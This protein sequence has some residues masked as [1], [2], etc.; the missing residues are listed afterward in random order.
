MVVRV[1]A[2]D[3]TSFLAWGNAPGIWS[4]NDQSA[5]SAG[6]LRCFVDFGDE[7]HLQRLGLVCRVILRRCPRPEMFGRGL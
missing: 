5:E 3:A 6:H 7:T 1:S 2:E 4:L